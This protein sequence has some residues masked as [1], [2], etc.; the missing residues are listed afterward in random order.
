M[1]AVPGEGNVVMFARISACR[2]PPAQDGQR[3]TGICRRN[4][5]LA[6]G[7]YAMLERFIVF[8]HGNSPKTG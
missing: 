5:A 7:R 2:N 3:I 8:Q 4:I 6:S 1:T